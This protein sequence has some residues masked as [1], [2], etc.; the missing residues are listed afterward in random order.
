M[1]KNFLQFTNG[2]LTIRGDVA[3]S[4]LSTTNFNVNSAGQITASAGT[5]GGFTISS[6]SLTSGSKIVLDASQSLFSINN[7]H[8]L[9]VNGL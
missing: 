9:N 7:L 6:T 4:S 2:V 5:I 8:V 1:S 3:A